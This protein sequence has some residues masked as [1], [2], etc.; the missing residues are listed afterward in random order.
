MLINGPKI[1]NMWLG[2]TERQIREIFRRRAK[3][4][5]VDILVF[6]FID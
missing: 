5:R 3:K 6:I 1:L 4:P 2:E